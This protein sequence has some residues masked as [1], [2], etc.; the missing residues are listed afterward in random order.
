MIP[1]FVHPGAGHK[2]VA[3]DSGVRDVRLNAQLLLQPVKVIVGNQL[4]LPVGDIG[5]PGISQI[6]VM[7]L[8]AVKSQVIAERVD[9]HFSDALGIIAGSCQFFGQGVLIV[10]GDSVLISHPSVMILSH[11][12]VEE[13][14]AAMQLGHA[15]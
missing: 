11:A 7:K 14:L 4:G 8:Y 5:P 12:G 10:P 13:A 6:A 2:A 3:F 15:L 9:M 1:F